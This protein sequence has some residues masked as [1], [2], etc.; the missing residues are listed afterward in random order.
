MT[1]KPRIHYTETDEALMWDHWQQ[2]ESLEKIAQLF[3]RSH[4]SVWSSQV[5]VD[6]RSRERRV[7]IAMCFNGGMPEFL[8]ASFAGMQKDSQ[9]I[10]YLRGIGNSEPAIGPQLSAPTRVAAR[11][12]A[13][14]NCRFVLQS[15]AQL[16]WSGR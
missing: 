15:I 9:K 4:G 10:P 11:L 8:F 7:S 5:L 13:R 14:G 6:N 3:D 12:Y 2:G 16:R 1:R